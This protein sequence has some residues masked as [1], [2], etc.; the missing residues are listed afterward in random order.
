VKQA[1]AWN[2]VVKTFAK[3]SDVAFA[4]VNLSEEPIRDGHNPGA[5]GWPTIRYF[6]KE[7]GY[8]GQ[9]YTQK[10]DKSMCDELG[11]VAMMQAYVEEAGHTSLCSVTTGAGCGDKEKAFIEIWKTK[12]KADVNAQITR[13]QGMAAGKMTAELKTWLNQR[14]AIL[15]QFQKE[16]AKAEL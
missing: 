16:H 13:L 15:S 2:S 3:N 6:N 9:A 7:T 10:T 4:D 11:D 8:G 5:G 1:P 14:M 12:S